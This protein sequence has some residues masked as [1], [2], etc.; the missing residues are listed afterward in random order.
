MFVG[1]YWPQN[2]L[3][4]WCISPKLL[5]P[6][7]AARPFGTGTMNGAQYADCWA[8]SAGIPAL[9]GGGPASADARY[10]AQR[11]ITES[12]PKVSAQINDGFAGS[13]DIRKVTCDCEVP[14]SAWTA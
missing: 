2:S 3:L 13:V 9:S 7:S 14:P 11:C 6:Y 4:D 1:L 10:A 12:C 5:A 8:H